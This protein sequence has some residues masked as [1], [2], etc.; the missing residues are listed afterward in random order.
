MRKILITGANSAIGTATEA[1]LLKSPNKYQ[2]DTLDMLDPNWSNYNFNG[3]DTVFHVAGLAH[4]TPKKKL[5]NK[6]YQVNTKLAIDTAKL[7]KAQGVKQFIF[8][9]SMIVYS[10]KDKIITKETIPNPDNFYGNSKLLAEE[11]LLKLADANFKITILR[12]PVVYGPN[13]RGNFIRLIKF[14]KKSFIFPN[15]NNKRSM[16]YIDNLTNSIKFLIDNEKDGIFFPQNS[17]Y[18]SSTEVVRLTAHKLKR[19]VWFT[20]LF[21]PIIYLFRSS[22][23]IFNKVFSDSYYDKEMSLELIDQN[24]TSN[25]ESINELLNNWKR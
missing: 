20:K 4:A 11:G 7:A 25:N 15:I 23:N 24:V 18:F 2:I 16:I 17:N 12:P 5:R 14:A 9:S 19:R 13:L 6:Y 10:K 3:Y 21:N 1:W 22:I 8:M